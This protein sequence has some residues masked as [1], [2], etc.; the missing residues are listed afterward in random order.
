MARMGKVQKA[1][2]LISEGKSD[3]EVKAKTGLMLDRIAKLKAEPVVEEAQDITMDDLHNVK[4]DITAEPIVMQKPAVV[5]EQ[6]KSPAPTDFKAAPIPPPAVIDINDY[7]RTPSSD[8]GGASAQELAQFRRYLAQHV[9]KFETAMFKAVTETPLP[10]EEQEM[11]QE[12]WNGLFK[13]VI[14]DTNMQLAIAGILV[15]TA[16]GTIFMLHQENIK[17]GMEKIK[18]RRMEKAKLAS[19][20][21]VTVV[22]S[23]APSPSHPAM[24]ILKGDRIR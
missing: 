14:K 8:S 22:A 20:G 7:G 13:C 24:A 17:K 15:V 11:L 23:P 21:K 16:H 5:S 18:G 4:M 19:D 9:T 12:S 10:P 3:E 1:R 2:K 6:P